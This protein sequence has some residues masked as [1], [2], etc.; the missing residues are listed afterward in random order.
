MDRI[1]VE[2]TAQAV[3]K[4]SQRNERITG[5][6]LGM[7]LPHVSTNILAGL[8]ETLAGAPYN[9]KA[10]LPDIASEQQ[11]EVDELFPV[12]EVIAIGPGWRFGRGRRYQAHPNPAKRFAE[13]EKRRA[14]AHVPL[15][16]CLC[17]FPSWR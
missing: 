1:Y 4:L 6:G 13:A 15:S 17:M 16:S 9:G 11:L 12:A 14:Q 8:I 10:D 5:G 3:H 2:M 7:I